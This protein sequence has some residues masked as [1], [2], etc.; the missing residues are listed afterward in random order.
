MWKDIKGYEGLYMVNEY[1]EIKSLPKKLGEVSRNRSI[2]LKQETNN[3]GYRRVTLSKDKKIK[4]I[5]VHKIVYENFVEDVEEGK[6]IN[7]KDFNPSNNYY[8]NLEAVSCFENS[9]HSRERIGWKL[10]LEDVVYIRTSDL[11]NNT[12]AEMFGVNKRHI[13][14]VRNGKRWK[15]NQEVYGNF[16]PSLCNYR[17]V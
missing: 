17:K 3:K 12:L 13:T 11:S 9:Y 10:S 2:I 4:K 5:F 16:V 6:Q 8:K 7:H 14:R 15:P 1:G